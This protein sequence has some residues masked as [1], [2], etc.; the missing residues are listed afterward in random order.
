MARSIN[1]QMQDILHHLFE[2]ETTPYKHT[3]K[4]MCLKRI[5]ELAENEVSIKPT[6]TI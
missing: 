4:K 2:L 5:I 3:V 6:Y 1:E